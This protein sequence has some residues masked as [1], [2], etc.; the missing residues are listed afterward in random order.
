MVQPVAARLSTLPPGQ[1]VL[2]DVHGARD[3]VVTRLSPLTEV[4]P[5]ARETPP[6][7]SEEALGRIESAVARVE[8]AIRGDR[9]RGEISPET[10][11]PAHHRY[12]EISAVV[13]RLRKDVE[14]LAARYGVGDDDDRPVDAL[15]APAVR[16]PG[17]TAGVP[18][19][20]R[21]INAPLA[22]WPPLA[23]AVLVGASRGERSQR[24]AS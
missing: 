18:S 22:R 13:A 3:G 7:D 1:P 20:W 10:S 16:S 15:A 6:A 8:D 21:C 5:A 4:E 2:V 12:L 9:P 11:T 19:I 17:R 23:R 24:V 14:D